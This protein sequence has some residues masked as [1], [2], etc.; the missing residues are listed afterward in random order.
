M[1]EAVKKIGSVCGLRS[2]IVLQSLEAQGGVPYARS[3]VTQVLDEIFR[4]EID[5]G[6]A[7]VTSLHDGRSSLLW[8]QAFP[9]VISL[10]RDLAPPP[11][12]SVDGHTILTGDAGQT[13]FLYSVLEHVRDLHALIIDDR[14]YAT[15]MSTYY[16]LGS[17]IQRPGIIVFLPMSPAHAS[18]AGVRRLVADLRSGAADNRRHLIADV[19]P[20]AGGPGMSYELL[21]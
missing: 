1:A 3:E 2:A 10:N 15:A 16:L 5:T 19:I 20:E 6:Q 8:R 11:P 12:P 7:L 18:D 21:L 4:H 17:K 9:H 13:R 14:Y